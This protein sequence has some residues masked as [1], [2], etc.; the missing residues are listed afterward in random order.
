[1]APVNR[2]RLSDDIFSKDRFE[3]DF[4]GYAM[5]CPMG[6]SRVNYN[7]LS[8]NKPFMLFLM[9]IPADNVNCWTDAL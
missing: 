1:M 9:V 7:M 3:Y 4:D 8:H 6:H 5:R 2:S